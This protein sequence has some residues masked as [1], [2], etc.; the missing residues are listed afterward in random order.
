MW[1][2]VLYDWKLVFFMVFSENFV[3]KMDVKFGKIIC[4]F[5]I[6]DFEFIGIGLCILGDFLVCLYNLKDIF[7]KVVKYS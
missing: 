4:L 1:L 6:G 7:G 5:L 3:M 2:V